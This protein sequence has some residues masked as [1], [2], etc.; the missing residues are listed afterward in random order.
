MSDEA[1]DAA[2]IASMIKEQAILSLGP[3]P[4]DLKLLIFERGSEW[5]CGLSPALQTSDVLSRGCA[6]DSPT[7]SEVGAL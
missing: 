1:K 7:T 3:W 5:S 4:A 6:A 2:E